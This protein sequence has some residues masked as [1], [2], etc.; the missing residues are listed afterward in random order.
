L[1]QDKFMFIMLIAYC[2]PISSNRLFP[3]PPGAHRCSSPTPQTVIGTGT[4]S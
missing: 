3:P 2:N 4:S 1:Q